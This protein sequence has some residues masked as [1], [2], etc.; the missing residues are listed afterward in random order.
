MV[1]LHCPECGIE[2]IF[3]PPR[4]N[5]ESGTV[6]KFCGNRRAVSVR[7]KFSMPYVIIGPYA[8]VNLDT[9]ADPIC[10]HEWTR[11]IG[12]DFDQDG[13]LLRLVRCL[14]CDLLIHQYLPTV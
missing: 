4:D 10:Q 12:E 5:L 1:R 7:E 2:T 14:K 3:K 11:E 8:R 13:R 9:L 6:C